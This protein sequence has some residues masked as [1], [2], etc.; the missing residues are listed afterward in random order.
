MLRMMMRAAL[1]ALLG[2]APALAADIAVEQPWAR[3]AMQGGVGGAF[4]VLRN[5]GAAADRLVSASSPVAG[6]VE[7]HTTIRDGDVMRMRPVTSIELPPKGAVTLAPGGL[8]VMLIGLTKALAA[9]EQVPITLTFER[10]GAVTVQAA[11]QPAGARDAGGMGHG[12]MSP[13][14]TGPNATGHGAMGAGTMRH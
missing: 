9:G 11:V 8:H 2:G 6:K 5:S 10:A 4:M 7:I 3:A 12:A 1:L 13:N 14:A